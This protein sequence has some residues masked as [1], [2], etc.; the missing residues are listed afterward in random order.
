MMARRERSRSRR[1]DVFSCPK[2][3]RGDDGFS[4]VEVLVSMLILTIGMLAIAGLLAVTTQMALGAREAGRSTRLAQDKIDEL[5]KLNFT[6]APAIAIGGDLTADV[7]NYSEAPLGGVT[8]RWAVAAGPT[9]DLRILTLRVV[10]MR[11]EQYRNTDLTTI[12]RKW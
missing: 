1:A 12:I 4:L 6:T 8:L 11:S 10:N 3:L 9:A 5:M 2:R 7:A